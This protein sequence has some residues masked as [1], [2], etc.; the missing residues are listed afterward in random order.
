MKILAILHVTIL[1]SGTAKPGASKR[2]AQV[3]ARLNP[4]QLERPEAKGT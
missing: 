1:G 3:F 4:D 2:I